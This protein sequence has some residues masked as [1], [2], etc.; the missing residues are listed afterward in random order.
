ML[1]IGTDDGIYRWFE[2][3]NW[4]IFHG[5]QEHAVVSLASPGRGFLAVLDEAG[6]VYESGNNGLSW[7]EVPLPDDV[8]TP[9]SLA[10]GGTPASLVI[11]TP[12]PFSLYRRMMG[13][14]VGPPRQSILDRATNYFDASTKSLVAAATGKK[15]TTSTPA[16]S[17]KPKVDT[18]GWTKL[19]APAITSMA[20]TPSIRALHAPAVGNWFAT[21]TGSG[22]YRSGD[23]GATWTKVDG[24]PAGVFGFR[25][26]PGKDGHLFLATSDG[27]KFTSDGGATWEDRSRGLDA[28]RAIQAI[29]VKPG[30]PDQLLVAAGES[31]KFGVFESK[32][33]GKTWANLI[34]CFPPTLE[35]DTVADIRWDPSCPDQGVV[36]FRSGELWATSNG[37]EY[38]GPFARQ[39][40]SAR[41]VCGI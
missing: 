3:Q 37:G 5:F 39:I 16:K 23:S 10:V 2:G 30:A 21:V 32:D 40:R 11:A 41:A 22:L 15:P 6:R 34:R 25:A 36:A 9:T 4:P 20:Q 26:V 19:G 1:L 28:F 35:N 27:V 33:G 17:A 8:T 12:R 24:L 31:S 38:W 18:K 7:R 13:S 29:E 14:P